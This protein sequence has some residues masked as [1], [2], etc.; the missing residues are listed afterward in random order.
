MVALPRLCPSFTASDSLP[1]LSSPSFICIL[2]FPYLHG[3]KLKVEFRSQSWAHNQ[4]QNITCSLAV[5]TGTM[6]MT[7]TQPEASKES[8]G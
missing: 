7:L 4:V 1:P 2:N 8:R 6:F 3:T 5:S